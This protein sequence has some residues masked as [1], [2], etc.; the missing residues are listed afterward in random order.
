MI[1][2]LHEIESLEGSPFL[3]TELLPQVSG[4]YFV[5]N[6]CGDLMY[7][8]KSKNIR[9]RWRGKS[10]CSCHGLYLKALQHLE[11]DNLNLLTYWHVTYMEVDVD[12][13]GSVEADYI[14]HYHPPF[15]L[16]GKGL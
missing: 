5:W 1:L 3:H 9:R 16:Q 12:H 2:E 15:N 7:V 6:H 4:V 13:L 10:S 8:G 11:T 14:T